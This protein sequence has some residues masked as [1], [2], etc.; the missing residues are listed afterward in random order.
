MEYEEVTLVLE[1][2]NSLPS[3]EE[4]LKTL[5]EVINKRDKGEYTGPVFLD[6]QKA[7]D[8]VWIQGLIHKLIKWKT[9]PHLL[10][11]LKSYLEERKFTVKNGNSISEAKIMRE[12]IPQGGKIC[13]VLYSL[14]IKD[15][16]KPHEI[17]RPTSVFDQEI[18]NLASF[19]IVNI[20]SIQEIIDSSSREVASSSPICSQLSQ[21]LQRHK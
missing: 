2:G 7:F 11:L 15:I 5:K 9:P 16:K 21:K 18:A 13:P 10:Q 1:D 3:E 12:G 4:I 6:V 8:K 17:R 20:I 19:E 14:Y